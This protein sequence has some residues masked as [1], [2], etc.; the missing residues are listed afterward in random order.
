MTVSNNSKWSVLINAST[1]A[2]WCVAPIRMVGDDDVEQLPVEQYWCEDVAN[3]R[4]KEWE[5]ELNEE[6]TVYLFNDG[7]EVHRLVK[8]ECTWCKTE[9]MQLQDMPFKYTEC[10]TCVEENGGCNSL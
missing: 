10:P 4:A 7:L 1:N 8:L 3:R 5:L 6:R 9:Y 2:S